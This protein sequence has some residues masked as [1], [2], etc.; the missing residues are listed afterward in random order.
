MWYTLNLWVPYFNIMENTGLTKD[1]GYQAGVRKTIP[2]TLHDIWNFLFSEKGIQTWLGYYGELKWQRNQQYTT[3]YGTFICI[4][5]YKELSHVRLKYRKKQ[6]ENSSTIQLRV[7]PSKSG[8]T[9]SF[10]QEKLLDAEQRNEM[11]LHWDKVLHQIEKEL[12]KKVF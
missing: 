2:L 5:V 10:H 3:K 12:N 7:V 9:I 6:W 8:T 11:K 1:A 4:R